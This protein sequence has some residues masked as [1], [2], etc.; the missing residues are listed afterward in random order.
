MESTHHSRGAAATGR[1]SG[2][3]GLRAIAVLLVFLFHDTLLGCGWIGVQIFFVLSGYLIT[4]LLYRAKGVP[5]GQY[6]REFYGRRSLR[7]FPVYFAILTLFWTAS[8]LGLEMHGLRAGLPFA[9]TYTYN[10]YH[11]T[12]G[13]EH[14]RLISHF[15]SLCVEEQFYLI[16]PCLIFSVPHVASSWCCRPSSLPGQRF[17]GWSGSC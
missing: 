11:T 1:L 16:W 7:I 5:F 13:F 15:W 10:W 8:R 3:D 9:Y 2:L 12:A 14:S 6:V 4:G 17:A